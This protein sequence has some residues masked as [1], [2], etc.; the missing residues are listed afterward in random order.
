MLSDFVVSV[1]VPLY[2]SCVY[3]LVFNK[4]ILLFSRNKHVNVTTLLFFMLSL[5]VCFLLF[6]LRVLILSCI[7]F[8]LNYNLFV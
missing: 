7:F 5:I 8:L 4:M 6:T 3:L 1:F 2:L